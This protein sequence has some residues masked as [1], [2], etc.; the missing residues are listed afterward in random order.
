MRHQKNLQLLIQW[1]VFISLL[2]LGASGCNLVSLPPLPTSLPN[3]PEQTESS[4]PPTPTSEILVLPVIIRS[5]SEA[6][7]VPENT[8]TAI[9]VPTDT[10]VPTNMPTD[11]PAPTNTPTLTRAPE[12]TLLFTGVIVPARCVQ[13]AIDARGDANY[14]YDEVRGVI[15]AADLAVGT[16]NASLSDLS[17][18]TG[19]IETYVLV[20]DSRSAQAAASAGFDVMSVA[21][22][23]IK[24]CAGASCEDD[25]NW[26]FEDTLKNLKDNGIL[27]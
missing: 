25:Y 19:C 10:S 26:A 11:T 5:D 21:T 6:Y 1:V 15:A 4:L 13:S 27:A 24:N 22:N 14:V 9:P 3:T 8:A 12:I 17:T 23:H 7:P 2:W 18:H 16:L 20:G